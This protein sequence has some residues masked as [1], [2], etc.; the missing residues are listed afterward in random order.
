MALTDEVASGDRRRALEAMRDTL[1][2]HMTTAESSVVAQIAARLQA[3][4][5]AIDA[6]PTDSGVSRVDEVR[7]RREARKS[8]AAS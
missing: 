4:I 1:A 7:R 3:V 2:Q 6:L 5:D 8:K